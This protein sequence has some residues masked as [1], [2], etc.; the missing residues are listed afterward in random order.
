[1]TPKQVIEHFKTQTAAAAALNIG[2]SAVANWCK[3]G[4]VPMLRQMQYEQLTK[5][6]LKTSQRRPRVS[7]R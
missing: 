7:R 5:G 3:R 1:M 2:Q 4:S 6:K